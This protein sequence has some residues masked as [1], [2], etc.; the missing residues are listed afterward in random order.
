MGPRGRKMVVYKVLRKENEK[1]QGVRGGG[2]EDI[3]GANFSD[4]KSDFEV[5]GDF[6]GKCKLEDKINSPKK[7]K[8]AG[9]VAFSDDY[10]GPKHHPPN[11][12]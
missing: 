4:V 9:F 11:H 7:F 10:H 12:N 3:S 1:E 2:S 5:K 6:N 8:E